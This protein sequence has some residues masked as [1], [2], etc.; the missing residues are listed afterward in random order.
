MIA[1]DKRTRLD[2][3]KLTPPRANRRLVDRPRLVQRLVEGEDRPLTII[4]GPAGFGKTTL[5]A[6]WRKS[7]IGRG[8][9][10][11]WLSL[12]EQDKD[13]GQIF[14]YLVAALG[15]AGCEFGD[16]ALSVYQHGAPDTVE[17][18]TRALLTDVSAFSAELYAF[19][20]DFHLVDDARIR[21]V[22]LRL[23][24]E[25][26]DNFHIVLV[27]RATPSFALGGLRLRDRVT[28][29]NAQDLRFGHAEA[30][31]L[32][33]DRAALP[34]GVDELDPILDATEGWAAALQLAAHALERGGDRPGRV[35]ALAAE[36]GG[37]LTALSAE[38]LADLEPDLLDFLLQTSILDR[39]NAPLCEA[40]TGRTDAGAILARL[41]REIPFVVPLENEGGWYRYHHLFVQDLRERLVRRYVAELNGRAAKAGDWLAKHGSGYS[42]ALLDHLARECRPH[43][44]IVELHRRAARWL[45]SEGET[46]AAVQHALSAGEVTWA[47][48]MVEACA[49][50]LVAR[51]EMNTLLAWLERLPPDAVSARGR[52]RLARAWAYVLS[53]QLDAAAREIAALEGAPSKVRASVEPAEFEILKCAFAVY[54]DDGEA[55]RPLADAWPPATEEPFHLGAGANVAMV[56][57]IYD[58]A[59]DR[60]R[61]ISAWVSERPAVR[62]S[63]FPMVYRRCYVGLNF[64]M[65]GRLE[66]AE[67]HYRTAIALAEE[68]GGRRCAPA[69]VAAGFLASLLYE[70]DRLDEIEGVLAGRYDVIN[71]SVTPDGIIRA[72]LSG[73]RRRFALG[74]RAGALELVEQLVDHGRARG[75]DRIIVSGLAEEVRQHLAGEELSRAARAQEEID[76]IAAR[77]A[78]K[79]KGTHGEIARIVA[80]SAARLQTGLGAPRDALERLQKILPAETDRDRPIIAVT[81]LMQM[82]SAHSAAGDRD[83]ALARFEEA[84]RLG[85]R[86]GYVRTLADE[87]ERAAALAGELRARTAAGRAGFPDLSY[88]ER[89]EKAA[90]YG[91]AD[92]ASSPAMRP[93]APSGLDVEIEGLS[94][95]EREILD[96][97]SQGLQNKRIARALDL[98]EDTVKWYLKKIY[99][100]LDVSSRVDAVDKARELDLL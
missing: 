59:F 10:V 94:V 82:A 96:L 63:Y 77:Y 78:D 74:E 50:E 23:V 91:R 71:R 68:R 25:A 8:K 30:R 43:A 81:V 38:M 2:D 66:L 56:P 4:R 20:D 31:A 45:A 86:F 85:L 95:R 49:I 16:G 97:L 35:K 14:R 70:L 92:A 73:A 61:Q 84:A 15:Q 5:A 19:L 52:L 28:E 17:A 34:G 32:L 76:R 6:Q 93:A 7:L 3:A 36:G 27:A 44:D 69:C 75:Y 83:A 87:G 22:V 67:E 47:I 13:A 62:D 60:V 29:V 64:K 57:L 90:C 33:E 21:E 39:L 58:G 89:L 99:Q 9:H 48:D 79:R 100:K 53:C 42:P 18:F 46:I 40:V 55:A 88:L 24:H 26:P 41:E 11:G 12:D 65:Q 72:Y 51:A 1:P 98:A 54:A 80:L 37:L